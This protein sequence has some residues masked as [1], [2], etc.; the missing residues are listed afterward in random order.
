MKRILFVLLFLFFVFTSNSFSSESTYVLPYPSYMPGNKLYSVSLLW[1]KFMQY[2]Y[3]GN[4]AQFSYNLQQS[5]KYLVQAKTLFEYKQYL[6]GYDALKKS[7]TFFGKSEQALSQAQKE[8]KSIDQ[9]KQLYSEAAMKHIEVLTDLKLLV[10][11]E[12]TWTPEK[13]AAQ[14][15]NIA[16]LIDD[17]LS[18]RE[19]VYEKISNN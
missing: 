13:E 2:W 18:I 16:Q 1:D 9:K 19:K 14:K 8:N 15:L 6:L 4:L 7:N 12:F 11:A 3:F 10:P 5:D 17:S